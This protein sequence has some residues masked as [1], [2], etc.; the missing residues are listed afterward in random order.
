MI[1]Q[2]APV[3]DGVSVPCQLVEYL[4]S[5]SM[6]WT[7]VCNAITAASAVVAAG[8]AAVALRTW[9]MQLK[10]QS[11]KEIRDQLLNALADWQWL[12]ADVVA[13]LGQESL[14]DASFA[15]AEEKIEASLRAVH[16]IQNLNFAYLPDDK[17]RDV[18]LDKVRTVMASHN[19]VLGKIRQKN[20]VSLRDIDLPGQSFA[21]IEASAFLTRELEK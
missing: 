15:K 3:L 17:Q 20:R 18:L 7:L 9:K 1:R 5:L 11:R 12:F 19:L 2:S 16:R 21:V 6:D 4:L 10:A 13:L 8:I 14:N